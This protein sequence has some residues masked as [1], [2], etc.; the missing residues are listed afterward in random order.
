MRERENFVLK[1]EIPREGER[2]YLAGLLF[3]LPPV[4]ERKHEKRER[5]WC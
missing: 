1:I 2:D 3:G 4:I 5:R